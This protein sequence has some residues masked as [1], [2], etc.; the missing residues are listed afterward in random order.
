MQRT[1]FKKAWEDFDSNVF[2]SDWSV[3]FIFGLFIVG[4][5]FLR[6][7]VI[8]CKE[9]SLHHLLSAGA[10]LPAGVFLHHCG[11]VCPALCATCHGP[12]NQEY[13]SPLPTEG[14]TSML[15]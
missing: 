3:P 8:K 2:L 10:L 15:E 4:E 5:V 9:A 14:R 12:R 6:L 13:T 11:S 7:R 1:S